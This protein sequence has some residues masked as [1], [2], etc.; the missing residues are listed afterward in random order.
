MYRVLVLANGLD[1]Q[2]SLGAYELLQFFGPP[3]QYTSVG[4]GQPLSELLRQTCWSRELHCEA[5]LRSICHAI[6]MLARDVN[7]SECP[8]GTMSLMV[9]GHVDCLPLRAL[10]CWPLTGRCGGGDPA[11]PRRP[12][13]Y[14]RSLWPWKQP[15]W[16]RRLVQ[17]NMTR[18]IIRF[19]PDVP[20]SRRTQGGGK[21]GLVRRQLPP[22]GVQ[23]D[24]GYVIASHSGYST[25]ALRGMLRAAV[26]TVKR[27]WR[28]SR[29]EDIGG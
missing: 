9:V 8:P 11:K 2:D 4:S 16:R 13:S 5:L 18:R 7:T 19:G 17:P 15:F 3:S 12:N 10:P 29:G 14:W 28:S 21:R 26:R 1:T 20:R 25:A 22:A 27:G 6:V 23:R 24:C